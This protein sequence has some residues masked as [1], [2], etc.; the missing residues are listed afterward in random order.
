MDADR[1]QW[2][3][4]TRSVVR[5]VVTLKPTQSK[6]QDEYEQYLTMLQER[7]RYLA[8]V[9]KRSSYLASYYLLLKLYYL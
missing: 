5:S 2:D 6:A 4:N 8:A 3:D 9:T 1:K 7:N